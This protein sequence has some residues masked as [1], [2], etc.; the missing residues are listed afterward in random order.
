M[1]RLNAPPLPPTHTLSP[2]PNLHVTVVCRISNTN[3]LYIPLAGFPPRAIGKGQSC[4]K[5]EWQ[6][7]TCPA[8][9]PR[10]PSLSSWPALW[11]SDASALFLPRP[12]DGWL[13][14]RQRPS[15]CSHG[16][17]QGK[18]GRRKTYPWEAGEKVIPML[19][20]DKH[21]SKRYFDLQTYY[22][23]P[24]GVVG[25]WGIEKSYGCPLVIPLHLYVMTLINETACSPNLYRCAHEM[26]AEKIIHYEFYSCYL[27]FYNFR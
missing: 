26:A 5:R 21:G 8:T 17:K 22:F 27:L 16:R 19:L 14:R 24:Q 11:P 3:M 15:R 13:R 12:I 23:L 7:C 25:S 20:T 6:V 4:A 2:F 1:F 18:T 9:T 10:C